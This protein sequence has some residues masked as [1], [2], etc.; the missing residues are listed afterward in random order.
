MRAKDLMSRPVISVKANTTLREIIHLISAQQISGLPVVNESEEVIGII[1]LREL[2]LR[3]KTLKSPDLRVPVLF[4]QIVDLEH[5]VSIYKESM[6]I[7]AKDIMSLAPVCVDANDS[8]NQVIWTMVENDLYTIPVLRSG[9]L[10]GVVT[11][12][13]FIQFLARKL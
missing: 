2:F 13:D 8:I 7:V 12:G 11:R 4:E 6:N 1:S 10:A 3:R 5:V 9:K